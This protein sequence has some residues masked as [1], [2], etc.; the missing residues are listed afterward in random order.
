MNFSCIKLVSKN[1]WAFTKDCLFWK[2]TCN[3]GELSLKFW[4]RFGTS[5]GKCPWMDIAVHIKTFYQAC[6]LRINIDYPLNP[7]YI[8]KIFTY[9]TE[10]HHLPHRNNRDRDLWLGH[11]RQICQSRID[12]NVAGSFQIFQQLCHPLLRWFVIFEASGKSVVTQLVGQALA[13]S[14]SSSK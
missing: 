14:F 13:Q 2:P 11:L 1:E 5:A 8:E 12:A 7:K 3:F 6:C 9:Y 4:T 10:P